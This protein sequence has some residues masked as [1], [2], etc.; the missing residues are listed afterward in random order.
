MA[1]NKLTDASKFLS[2]I[3]R[4]EPGAIGVQLDSE[5]WLSVRALIDG[6]AAIGRNLDIGLIEEVVRDN[7]KKRFSLSEDRTR[8]RAVQGHSTAT[9]TLTHREAA[10][11]AVLYHGTATRFLE[12]IQQQ[13][14]LPGQR[15]HVHL[16]QDE[17]TARD[18]GARYG[19]PVVLVVQA[20]KMHQE[21]YRFFQAENGVWLTDRVPA[22]FLA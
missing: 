16:A 19:A 18:I 22:E 9:V 5:G 4:H 12:S 15:H 21:G 7:D 17:G 6:A 20:T 10:P 8:I 1:T 14:L 2:Y 11:P 13:G 3:L